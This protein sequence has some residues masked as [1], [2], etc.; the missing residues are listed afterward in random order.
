MLIRSIGGYQDMFGFLILGA[1]Q[2]SQNF[3]NTPIRFR[4]SD[5][6]VLILYLVSWSSGWRWYFAVMLQAKLLLVVGSMMRIPALLLMLSMLLLWFLPDRFYPGVD[7]CNP[8]W[9]LSPLQKRLFE[10]LFFNDMGTAPFCPILDHPRTL[11]IFVYV[12]AFHMGETILANVSQMLPSKPVYGAMAVA[13]SMTIGILVAMFDYPL[14]F[15]FPFHN[16]NVFTWWT[17]VEFLA[18]TLQPLLLV[19]GMTFV[20]LNMTFW[21]NATLAVYVFH[22]NFIVFMGPLIAWVSFYMQWDSTGL[23]NAG[24]ILLLCFLLQT[25]VGCCGVFILRCLQIAIAKVARAVPTCVL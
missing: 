14:K 13:A 10:V 18:F 2:D 25:V 24:I 12:A 9:N 22:Y 20:R 23:L 15:A 4:Q 5:L 19:Y 21:G 7:T 16:E 17:L 8:S 6:L 3:K 11:F 1:Y